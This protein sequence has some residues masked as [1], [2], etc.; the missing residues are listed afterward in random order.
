MPAEFEPHAATW[1]SW[2][3]KESSWPGKLERIPPILAAMVRAVVQGEDVHILVTAS[4]PAARVRE[5]L[6][7]AGVP[8]QRVHLHEIP[9]DDAWMRDHGPT[10]ITRN[11]EIAVV[12]W[13]FN[14]WGGK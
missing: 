2:P 11:A 6:A 7:H 12:D 5:A 14:A 9:T 10:F 4:A 3:H 8:M 1:L 13:K